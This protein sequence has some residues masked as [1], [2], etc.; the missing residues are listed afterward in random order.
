MKISTP[1]QSLM[2]FGRY[3]SPIADFR[4]SVDE[5]EGRTHC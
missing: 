5:M 3:A 2:R 1:H 4:C